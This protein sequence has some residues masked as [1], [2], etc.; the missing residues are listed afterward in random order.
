VV[1]VIP[2]DPAPLAREAEPELE[3]PRP[4]TSRPTTAQGDDDDPLD[5]PLPE[6]APAAAQPPSF[7]HSRLLSVDRDKVSMS[8]PLQQ[9]S[10]KQ[11][12]E[13][14]VTVILV[15]MAAIAIGRIAY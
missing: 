11:Q 8:A 6:I 1:P 2:T 10:Q 7:G 15:A 9:L 3:A 14:A 4:T 5:P 13:V 12:A